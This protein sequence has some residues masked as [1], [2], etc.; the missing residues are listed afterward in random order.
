MEYARKEGTEEA[1]QNLDLP[2]GANGGCS[3]RVLDFLTVMHASQGIDADLLLLNCGLHDI[4][5]DGKTGINQVPLEEYRSNLSA[6]VSLV[7]Q[8]RVYPVWIRTTPFDEKIHNAIKKDFSRFEA[9]GDRYN[10]AADEIMTAS[11]IPIID[12]HTFTLN[13][14]ERLYLDHVHF[15]P[16]VQQQQAAY[17]A[18]WITNP[19]FLRQV[20]EWKALQT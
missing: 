13:L 18:G 20:V 10:Q 14:G 19:L 12:L 9:D 5:Q 3:A 7:S 15:L 1:L 6:I 16:G 17:I 11:N 4:K 2:K 8:M